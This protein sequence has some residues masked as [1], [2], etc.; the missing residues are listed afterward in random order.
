MSATAGL[1]RE[2]VMRSNRN[3]NSAKYTKGPCFAFTDGLKRTDLRH[4]LFTA[5][6]ERKVN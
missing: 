2:L 6:V 3:T 5:K 4:D 1:T